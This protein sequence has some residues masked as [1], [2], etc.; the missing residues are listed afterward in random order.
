[1]VHIP[2]LCFMATEFCALAPILHA[3]LLFSPCSM[4]R[5][6]VRKDCYRWVAKSAGVSWLA[7]C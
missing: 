3:E 4:D 7:G 6:N 5:L 1:M 2:A